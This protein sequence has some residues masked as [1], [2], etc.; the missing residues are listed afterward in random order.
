MRICSRRERCYKGGAKTKSYSV[1]IES[2]EQQRQLLFQGMEK[3]KTKSRTRYRIEAKNAE[4]KNVFGYDRTSF[5]NNRSP[6][7]IKHKKTLLVGSKGLFRKNR[8]VA[9]SEFRIWL[10]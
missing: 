1:S 7:D 3:F 5:P 8:K 9:K 10:L 6:R 2:D 4:L